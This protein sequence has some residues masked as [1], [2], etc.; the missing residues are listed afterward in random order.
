MLI[1]P[2]DL[3]LLGWKRVKRGWGTSECTF[4]NVFLL[5]VGN[6]PDWL[7]VVVVI[8]G[9]SEVVRMKDRWDGGVF[10]ANDGIVLATLL[11]VCR[12]VLVV[13]VVEHARA[14]LIFVYRACGCKLSLYQLHLG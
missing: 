8:G 11:H 10:Q 2:V 7:V 6:G 1:V 3:M 13:H 14:G 5:F 9:V 4:E 12:L